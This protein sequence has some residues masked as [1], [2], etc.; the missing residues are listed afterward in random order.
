METTENNFIYYHYGG[1]A[2]CIELCFHPSKLQGMDD[3]N[4]KELKYPPI[5]RKVFVYSTGLFDQLLAT[6]KVYVNFTKK[7]CTR[8]IVLKN[9]LI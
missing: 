4:S 2:V 8:K 9:I 3:K 1:A 6:L 7:F 5:L